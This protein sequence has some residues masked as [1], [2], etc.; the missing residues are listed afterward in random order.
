MVQRPYSVLVPAAV[1]PP[2]WFSGLFDGEGCIRIEE[3]RRKTGTIDYGPR[4]SI[5]MANL[6]ILRAF[7]ARFGGKVHL[8]KDR[9]LGLKRTYTWRLSSHK[10]VAAFISV[11][12]PWLIEKRA[13]AVTMSDYLDK[14]ACDGSKSVDQKA[15]Y[16]KLKRQKAA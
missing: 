1:R 12:S 10:S 8:S 15:F 7:A 16:W 6:P 11:I 14:V 4:I 2:E 5:L 13:Q 9:G 3:N